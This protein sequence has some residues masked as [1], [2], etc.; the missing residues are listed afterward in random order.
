[1]IP[2]ILELYKQKKFRSALKLLL[3]EQRKNPYRAEVYL[4]FFL[5]YKK[6]NEEKKMLKWLKEGF[7]LLPDSLAISELYAYYSIFLFKNPNSSLPAIK[8]LIEKKSFSV[9]F[10]LSRYYLKKGNLEKALF[11]S[12]FPTLVSNKKIFF[13]LRFFLF[14]KFQMSEK[15][16]KY[17]KFY[18]VRKLTGNFSFQDANKIKTNYERIQILK[19]KGIIDLKPKL[20]KNPLFQYWIFKKYGFFIPKTHLC[21]LIQLLKEKNFDIFL[22]LNEKKKKN[23]PLI[24][25]NLIKWIA[26]ITLGAVVF[27]F[28]KEVF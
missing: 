22:E 12:K 27:Y 21:V 13:R 28:L 7:Y 23:K 26:L 24:S 20:I 19:K 17:Q 9:S 6:L 2:K 11:H 8:N 16:K 25:E 18:F 1:M 14:W 3:K 5:I 15:L 4:L 10:L